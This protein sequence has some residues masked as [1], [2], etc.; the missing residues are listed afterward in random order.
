MQ[1]GTPVAIDKE[2]TYCKEIELGWL[3]F[4]GFTMMRY[5]T[6]V[7]KNSMGRLS[8]IR[9]L[10]L[11]LSTIGLTTLTKEK[12]YYYI[13]LEAE[14][15]KQIT[16]RSVKRTLEK[17]WSMPLPTRNLVQAFGKNKR[18]FNLS[19]IVSKFVRKIDLFF[20]WIKFF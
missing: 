5:I 14:I 12:F 10:Q 20:T 6:K 1:D 3:L 19:K 18:I 7:G 16:G 9:F 13:E 11:L 2:W 4:R 17:W 15:Q 8:H